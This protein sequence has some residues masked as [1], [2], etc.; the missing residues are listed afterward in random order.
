MAG[1]QMRL[2]SSEFTNS[3]VHT[4]KYEVRTVTA[5]P[6]FDPLPLTGESAHVHHVPI[7]R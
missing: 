6:G 4:P 5:N 3:M 7:P 1:I 2:F